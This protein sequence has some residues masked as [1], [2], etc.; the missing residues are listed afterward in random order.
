M[1]IRVSTPFII[2]FILGSSF[3]RAQALPPDGAA[4]PAEVPP[5]P[6]PEAEP[7]A[8]PVQEE[9][10]AEATAPPEV[11]PEAAAP[12]ASPV[13]AAPPIDPAPPVPVPEP[14]MA[15]E[16]PPADAPPA[17][18]ITGAPGDG[19]TVSVGEKFSL[20]VKSR[21]QIR[22]QLDIPREDDAGERD[23]Q[24]IATIQTARVYLGGFVYTPKLTYQLQLAVAG[25]DYRDGAT[26]PVYDAYLDYKM[27][28]DLSARVGQYFVPFDRLRTVKESALQMADRPRPIGE[29]T[30]DRDVGLT[31]YS[32]NFLGDES[33]VA[34]RLGVFGGGG[35]NLTVGR[36]PAALVV[37]RLE[38]RP[39]GPIDDD[40]EGDLARR[41]KPGL[42]LG[43]GFANN[44]NTNRV[45]STT[46]ATYVGGTTDYTHAAVDLV[47]KWMGFAF[48]AEHLWRNA[49]EDEILSTDEEG[50]PVTEYT[51]S[52]RA[53][54]LQA[55]YAFDPPVEVVG[56]VSRMYASN[57]TDP[58]LVSEVDARGDELGAGLNYYI[59]G[60]KLKVQADWIARMP[61]GFELKEADHVTHLLL[62]ATF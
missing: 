33:P 10:P 12:P 22:Y 8:P 18:T 4:P 24:Q 26:S 7:P 38:L 45:R 60:H 32:N 11:A 2:A 52:G 5:A 21:F 40:S 20:N 23:L 14:A 61:T 30:L 17:A 28:R 46:G 27:H 19:L 16:A 41:E 15:A 53:W 62:D 6:P 29:F 31:L 50:E 49:S 25:R 1:N 44:W 9:P 47:F 3:V 13:E 55:S 34:W 39:L 36:E 59:N 54:I 48:Q 57:D 37:G 43:G 56:R 35:T 51:R 58:A 42:A